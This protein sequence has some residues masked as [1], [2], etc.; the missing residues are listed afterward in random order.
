MRSAT[1]NAGSVPSLPALE[2]LPHGA[3]TSQSGKPRPLSSPIGRGPTAA[4]A[5]SKQAAQAR[6]EEDL[7]LDDVDDDEIARVIE[8]APAIALTRS[9]N[10]PSAEGSMGTADFSMGAAGAL[11]DNGPRPKKQY[12][13]TRKEGGRVVLSKDAMELEIKQ[14]RS[15]NRDVYETRVRQN[16]LEEQVTR[17]LYTQK[18]SMMRHERLARERVRQEE[19]IRREFAL[20]TPYLQ[21]KARNAETTALQ[22]AARASTAPVFSDVQAI[23]Q[24]LAAANLAARSVVPESRVAKPASV[25]DLAIRAK[26]EV[27]PTHSLMN[28]R[29]QTTSP[30]PPKA[31]LLPWMPDD[32]G[33]GGPS[34]GGGA[35]SGFGGASHVAAK[36][37]LS[38]IPSLFD[39]KRVAD[40]DAERRGEARPPLPLCVKAHLARS[41]PP[42]VVA[43]KMAALRLACAL[44]AS[45]PRVAIFQGMMGWGEDATP[46]DSTKAAACLLLMMWLKPPSDDATR[47]SQRFVSSEQGSLLEAD[48]YALELKLS[49]VD[50]ILKHL[51]RKRLVSGKGLR[52]LG[53]EASRME[54]P[55]PGPNEPP[56]EAPCVDV[57]QLLLRWMSIWGSWEWRE[58]RD[59]LQSVIERFQVR[60]PSPGGKKASS[61]SPKSGKKASRW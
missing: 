19:R 31:L 2:G 47:V 56:R 6:R 48:G 28:P 25:K 20:G 8:G 44:H 11:Y 24:R 35:S 7:E 32:A 60:S 57:D 46:W 33:G 51:A 26:G 34:A 16:Y 22:A 55:P 18:L 39:A 30:L 37:L 58:D 53:E 49:D 12:A 41:A 5:L 50:L 3:N 59:L 42:E 1:A 15:F 9:P 14:M 45:S 13:Y 4:A 40:Y 36:A 38:M 27:P 54:L 23:E 21:T 29:N 61:S 43:E 52:V 10:R 17:K